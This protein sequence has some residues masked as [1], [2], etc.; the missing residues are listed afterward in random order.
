MYL[1][2][3]LALTVDS[4][5]S[6]DGD[7]CAQS[8]LPSVPEC[9]LIYPE[10]RALSCLSFESS[11][12]PTGPESQPSSCALALR[13]QPPSRFCFDGQASRQRRLP[14]HHPFWCALPHTSLFLPPSCSSG[15]L[16]PSWT[17]S[18][19]HV[20]TS[21]KKFSLRAFVL[22]LKTKLLG[23]DRR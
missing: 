12:S 3:L 23:P 15:D 22:P 2:H 10:A 11:S 1:Y 7:S 9:Y 18:P 6:Q 14:A 17:L 13:P 8:G 4:G 21:A 19:P 5:I 16:S 20:F